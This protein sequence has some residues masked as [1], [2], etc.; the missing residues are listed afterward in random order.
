MSDSVQEKVSILGKDYLIACTPEERDALHASARYLDKKM[1]EVR[2]NG[3]I[4]GADRIAVMVALNM[5]HE[6]LNEQAKDSDYTQAINDR[7]RLIQDKIDRV[8][9]EEDRQMEL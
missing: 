9:D 6:L 1:R 2:D 4:L 8:L 7:L 5:A 3:K